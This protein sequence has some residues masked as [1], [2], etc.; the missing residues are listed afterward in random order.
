MS[1]YF[2]KP[3]SLGERLKVEFDLSNFVTKA[4]IKIVTGVDISKFAK[5]AD[6]D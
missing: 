6:L 2:P 1:E 4:D 3:K 5:K